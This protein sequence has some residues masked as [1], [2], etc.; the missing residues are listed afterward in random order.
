MHSQPK[1][2]GPLAAQ[3]IVKL[4]AQTWHTVSEYDKQVSD[5]I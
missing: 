2:E 5:L 4:G 1:P 3:N